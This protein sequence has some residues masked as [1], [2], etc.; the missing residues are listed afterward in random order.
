M[1]SSWVDFG[2]PGG[3]F[4]SLQVS[5]LEGLEL[6]FEGLGHH[7]WNH[8]RQETPETCQTTT[9]SQMVYFLLKLE[10][11]VNNSFAVSACPARPSLS[12]EFSP[13]W[14][15]PAEHA[16]T[17]IYNF[18]QMV[19]FHI[20]LEIKVNNSFA[21]S[22]CPARSSFSKEFSPHWNGRARP[23]LSKKFSPHWN[24]STPCVVRQNG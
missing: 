12:K 13:H 6:I 4:W 14:N 7:K 9:Q 20:R 1:E 16:N 5:I 22:T 2:G 19:Y 21:V 10:I 15:K 3:R 8:E 24:G 17:N 23:S 11:K 18:I